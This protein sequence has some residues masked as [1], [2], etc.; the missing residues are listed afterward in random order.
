MTIVARAENGIGRPVS[1]IDGPDKVTG[2]ARYA[3]EHSAD[4]MVYGWIVSS[5]IAKGRIVRIDD[6]AARTIGGVLDILTHE[7]RPHIAW[8][9]R[10]YRDEVA[11]PGEPFR[12][13]YDEQVHFSFQP[14]ALVLAETLE[15]ARAGAVL[16]QVH[17]EATEHTTDFIAALPNAYVPKK[18]RSGIPMP[19]DRGDARR[20]F[21]AAPIRTVTDYT[22]PA[23]HHNPME[24]HGTTV[25]WPGDGS[26]LVYDKTQGP[27]NVQSYLASVFGLPKGKVTVRNP[28]VGGAFGS[29]LRPQYQVYLA[30]MAALHLKRSVRVA[31]TRQQM[32][33]HVHRPE[34]FQSVSLGV[35]E[36]GALQSVINKATTATSTYEDYMEN[37]VNWGLMAYRCPDAAGDYTLVALDTPTPGDMRAPGAASGMNVFECAIDEIAYAAKIDPL[38]FRRLNYTDVDPM[39]DK[40]FTSKALRQAYDLGATAFGWHDRPIEPR[41]MQDGHELT[42][43]GM[44]TGTW[45]AQFMKTS[46]RARLSA[47]G[48]LEVAT[49]ASDI[50]TGT[51]TILAQIA[52]DALGVNLD[53]VTVK[54]GDSDLP[55]SP[56]EGGSW[57]AASAG[58][59]VNLACKT[60]GR[61]L[62]EAARALDTSPFAGLDF[63]D[64]SLT[65]RRMIVRDHDALS[66]PIAEIMTR[67]NLP[68]LEADETA[69]PGIRGMVGQMTKARGTHSAVFAEV[70]V[71][72]QLGVVRVT[73]VVVAVAAG[74]I[75]NP[76]TAR[77]Q[78]LGGVVMGLGMALHEETLMDHRFGRPMNH[79]L[80]EYH[81]PAHADVEHIDVIF[82]EERDEEVSPLGV[83]GLGEIGIVGTA[84]AVSNAIFHATGRR[85]RH[86]PITLDKLL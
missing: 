56:V 10:S 73:R 22:F 27:Q 24:M 66:M 15:A 50:G 28:F 49:A 44:A 36:E 65:G 20:A 4:E 2:R 51:Y 40:P 35:N 62:F 38:A 78:I 39:S 61:K 82:V 14:V 67:A 57:M 19:S 34:L 25:V 5:T 12:A 55:A 45:D 58:A 43:W 21:A 13:L 63:D 86:F 59:A 79:N 74:R 47:N 18:K 72:D 37:I 71:D 33:S 48:N 7:N 69:S 52:S 31:M 17:Y 29:G 84:A 11:P 81:I 32:V 76:K 64:V 83:K 3:A 8:F 54:I 68:S 70:K 46:A 30:T 1:R 23:H 80:A 60:V 75:L 42:G 26:I 53:D 6:A 16:L 77:S 41:S 85:V 9:D